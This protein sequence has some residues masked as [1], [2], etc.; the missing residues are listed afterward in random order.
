MVEEVYEKGWWPHG[1]N[2][3]FSRAAAPVELLLLGTLRMLG[4]ACTF[5]CLEELSNVGEETQ[6]RFFH[7]YTKGSAEDFQAECSANSHSEERR[8]NDEQIFRANGFPG[9]HLHVCACV[10]VIFVRVC[11]CVPWLPV[12]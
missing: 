7:A 8:D 5:D 2:D 6:R 10:C 12:V 3:H 4:R 11:V 9:V 1:A